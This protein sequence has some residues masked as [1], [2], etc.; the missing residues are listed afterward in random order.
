MYGLTNIGGKEYKYIHCE[1]R[2]CHTS[3]LKTHGLTYT[4]VKDYE[5]IS[6]QKRFLILLTKRFMD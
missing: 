4:G 3:D 1:K 6:C 5:C 2:F